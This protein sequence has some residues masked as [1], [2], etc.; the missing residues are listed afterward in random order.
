MRWRDVLLV[1]SL[2]LNLAVAGLAGARYYAPE[3]LERLA[4]PNYTQLLPRNFLR[5]L[6]DARR[7]EITA[8]VKAYRQSFKDGRQGFRESVGKLA[9]ALDSGAAT[10]DQAVDS[11]GS[12]G[13]A[14]VDEGAK[15][16][17]E[18]LAKLTPEERKLLAKHLRQRVKRGQ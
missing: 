5:E 15:L 18:V 12:A 11:V 3:R 2:G 14:L 1:V 7:Q 6:P 16:A 13:T 10:L 8:L 9:D 4:G 17:K